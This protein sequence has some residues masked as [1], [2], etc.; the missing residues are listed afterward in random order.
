MRSQHPP[1][2]HRFLDLPYKSKQA[3]P[4]RNDLTR[5][6]DELVQ[7]WEDSRDFMNRMEGVFLQ[8]KETTHDIRST[9]HSVNRISPLQTL[10]H[11][12]RLEL[13]L[14][15]SSEVIPFNHLPELYDTVHRWL[16]INPT[17]DTD[18]RFFS[19]GWLHNGKRENDGLCFEQGAK[20]RLSFYYEAQGK[21]AL[22]AIRDSPHVAYGLT[23]QE[24]VLKPVPV[25]GN[26]YR[27]QTDMAPI[28]VRRLQ[29]SGD[30]EYLLWHNRASDEILTGL[31][32]ARLARV[33]LLGKHQQTRVYFDRSYKRAHSK[34]VQFH[35]QDY[36]GSVCPIHVEGTPEAIS[37]AW[38][39]GLG[40][41]N[42]MGFGALR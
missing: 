8:H 2:S 1:R 22:K 18:A 9:R 21:K 20:W 27:F 40:D 10:Q 14:S 13:T 17:A 3:S 28:V 25:F 26:Q 36:R 15:P 30:T 41:L 39:V 7:N 38:L 32:R 24:A 4:Y 35:D 29:P 11:A 16:G 23:V 42:Q 6:A 12:M 5:A 34:M 31:L 37:F 19:Y 33:G